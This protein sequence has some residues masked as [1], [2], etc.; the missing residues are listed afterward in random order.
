M[1]TSSHVKVY[2]RCHPDLN[3]TPAHDNT[4]YSSDESSSDSDYGFIVNSNNLSTRGDES[5]SDS[6]RTIPYDHSE[7]ETV[8]D[9]VLRSNNRTR[10]PPVKLNDYITN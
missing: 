3:R 6:D 1:R 10:R 4:C 8:T 9:A 2:R 5:D 7:D